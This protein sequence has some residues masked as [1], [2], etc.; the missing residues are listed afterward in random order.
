MNLAHRK[1][2]ASTF[3]LGVSLCLFAAYPAQPTFAESQDASIPQD[4]ALDLDRRIAIE[5]GT[6]PRWSDPIA[7]PEI[8]AEWATPPDDL[9]AAKRAEE[10]IR[11]DL[12]ADMPEG[13]DPVEV[14]ASNREAA[15][16]AFEEGVKHIESGR[17]DQGITALRRSAR[18]DPNPSRV[19]SSLGLALVD[20]QNSIAAKSALRE[21][22]VRGDDSIESLYAYGRLAS[23]FRE[24]RTAAAALYAA[25]NH[26]DLADDPAFAPLIRAE[27]GSALLR[28]G[29]IDAASRNLVTLA[30][31]P[32]QFEA[33]TEHRRELDQLYRNRRSLMVDA[34]EASYSIEEYDRSLKLSEA[35]G[36]LPGQPD[37]EELAARCF[38]LLHAGR[39]ASAAGVVLQRFQSSVPDQF[40]I[41][42]LTMV[43]AQSDTG[44][45]IAQRIQ[46]IE[47]DLPRADRVRARQGFTIA[48]SGMLD[49]DADRVDVLRTHLNRH[50]TDIAVLTRFIEQASARQVLDFLGDHPALEPEIGGLYLHIHSAA[51]IENT[52]QGPLR[53]RQL[54]RQD[55]YPQATEDA[56]ELASADRVMFPTLIVVTSLLVDAARGEDA[57][58]LIDRAAD[59]ATRTQESLTVAR[60]ML[61]RG[62]YRDSLNIAGEILR[63]DRTADPNR[64]LA[65]HVAAE[66]QS[67]LG[68]TDEAVRLSRIA[69]DADP[70]EFLSSRFVSQLTDTP[71]DANHLRSVPGAEADVLLI[72]SRAALAREQFDLAER[73]LLEAWKLPMAS[74]EIAALLANLWLRTNSLPKAEQWLAEQAERFPDRERLAVLLSRVRSEDRRPEDS[75]HGIATLVASRP[76]N[77]TISRELERIQRDDFGQEDAWLS[78]ARARLQN[79]AK[80]FATF[81]ENAEIELIAGDLAQAVA[82]AEL[83]TD[84]APELRSTESR[85]VSRFLEE[86]AEDI[87]NRPRVDPEIVST[88]KRVF[89]RL[90]QPSRGAYLGRISIASISE[91]PDA[92]ELAALAVR[93]GDSHPDIQEEAFIYAAQSVMIASR[94]GQTTLEYDQSRELASELY[95]RATRELIPYPTKVLGEWI[96]F[97]QQTQDFFVL[98]EAIRSLG[99]PNGQQDRRLRDALVYLLTAGGALQQ[100]ALEPQMLA[101]AAH[102]LASQLSLNEQFTIAQVLYEEG[103]RITPDHVELNN[104][105]GYR[106]LERG[107]QVERAIEMIELA[108]TRSPNSAHI[109]DSMG[110]ARYKQGR[111]ADEVDPETGQT[112]LGAVTLL[113]QALALAD[114]QDETGMTG[115]FSADHFG[116][117]LWAA[118]ERER[119]ITAWNGAVTRTESAKKSFGSVTI[120]LALELELETLIERAREKVRAVSEDRRPDI[121]PYEGMPSDPEAGPQ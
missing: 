15:R 66:A 99:D 33:A 4:D 73:Q 50:P 115:A 6:P 118:G 14:S 81:A 8:L 114:Q 37:P 5:Q 3:T 2:V 53:L 107:E 79:S 62:R 47:S 49:L 63:D 70:Q 12:R 38:V 30:G 11:N 18:L 46:Q 26:P 72:Q 55:Q 13:F 94:T 76:G 61:E 57:D 40:A 106:L 110:W 71:A 112:N 97:S 27:L 41:D 60:A 89:D 29:F 98:G 113:Q 10:S 65:L 56:S 52:P 105:Y 1:R 23:Q 24:D 86:T 80:T 102:H 28:M 44:E 109:A 36:A 42:L 9:E 93:A 19:W 104:S 100:Q 67:L 32:N 58:A 22:I 39:P 101:D 82:L 117:A 64:L 84:L 75:L 83:A 121:Q 59:E 111:L 120:P 119:A 54:C 48:K 78:Q 43:A 77:P 68:D 31:L 21:A 35:A 69:L 85:L 92:D 108:Y 103:L 34:A 7:R 20:Q 25:L 16:D 87:V 96:E 74:D 90:D 91:V 116:D 17:I 51:E 88:F 95:A 45:M